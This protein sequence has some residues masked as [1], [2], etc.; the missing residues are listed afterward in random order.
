MIITCPHCATRYLLEAGVVRPPG[1]QVRCARCQHMWF[2]EPSQD[3]PTPIPIPVE[4]QVFTG[5]ITDRS[6]MLGPPPAEPA[7]HSLPRFEAPPPPKSFEPLSASPDS[8]SAQFNNR[9]RESSRGM[10]GLVIVLASFALF[11]LVFLSLPNEIATYWPQTASLYNALGY[12][13]NKSGFRIVATQTQELANSIQSLLSKGKSSTKPGESSPFP[14]LGFQYA[15]AP[16]GNFTTGLFVPTK[17]SW[18]LTA[19][20]HSAL[21]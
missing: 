20:V 19:K 15:T 11:L 17:T 8:M 16:A 4:E 14:V 7:M 2:Q 9:R 13:V 21:D 1:R 6:R 10:A 12:E 18:D 5:P 3:L